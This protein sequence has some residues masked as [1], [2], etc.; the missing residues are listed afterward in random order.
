MINLTLIDPQIFI[1]TYPQNDVDLDRL[2][3]GP[4]I[5]AVLNLQTD[6]DFKTLRINWPKIRQGYLERDMLC[7]RWPIADFSPEDLERRLAGAVNSLRDLVTDGHRVYVHCTAGVGRAPATVIGYLA[8]YKG[9]DL[10]EAY[11]LVKS[12]RA[13]DPYIDAIR[14]VHLNRN[15]G[16]SPS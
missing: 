4:K 1:G 13:C 16:G 9:M 2:K 10:D 8:W 3:S 12:L 6:A 15:T 11:N 5:S 7:R 14:S